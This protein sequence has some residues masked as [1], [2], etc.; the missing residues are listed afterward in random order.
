[1]IFEQKTLKTQLTMNI[2]LKDARNSTVTTFSILY[3]LQ[4]HFL[5]QEGA[6]YLFLTIFWIRI[7][8]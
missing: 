8:I 7:Y 5:W 2:R 6:G 3:G 4:V 1:M